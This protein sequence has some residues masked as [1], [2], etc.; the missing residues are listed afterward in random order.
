M[1]DTARRALDLLFALRPLLWIPAIALFAAGRSWGRGSGPDLDLIEAS[2]AVVLGS[3]LLLLGV[4]HVANA[5]RDR[6][7]DARNRKGRPVSRGAVGGRALV[8]LGAACAAGAVAL[9][10]HPA[11][12]GPPR[13]LLLTG[14]LLGAAYVVP[15]VEL[16]RRAGLD[17]LSHGLG[18]GVIAFLLGAAATGALSGPAAR[19]DAWLYA[20][21]ACVP[22]AAGVMAVAL[23]T[24]AADSAGDAS[25][26]QRTLAV[27]L[28]PSRTAR[29]ARGLAWGAALTGLLARE[30][31]PALWGIVAAAALSL[32]EEERR[33][34]EA[35]EREATEREASER[36]ASS[37][38]QNRLAIALQLLFLALLSVR[39]PIAP[40]AAVTLG[41]AASVYDRWRW[42]E[43][44]PWIRLR[45]GAAG[46][47]GGGAG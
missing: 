4:V 23:L 26:G 6:A 42:G 14:A 19:G 15:G 9:A 1:N 5:W 28:G 18:Y 41:A 34:E 16:K 20:A 45:A 39:A 33:V 12:A 10:A 32:A 30:A 27:A 7:G 17:L 31:A 2:G 44:Y 8:T 43:G 25:A 40:V 29:L 47:N 24:M 36:E 37:A 22:Y 3:L 46:K 13:A 38:A 35:T 21:A 11:A